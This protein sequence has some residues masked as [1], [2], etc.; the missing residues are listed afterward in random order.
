MP[1]SPKVIAVPPLA[2]PDAARVVL[3]AVLDPAWDEHGS[4][5]RPSCGRRRLGGGLGSGGLGGGASAAVSARL[6]R[7]PAPR[8]RSARRPSPARRHGASRRRASSRPRPRGRPRCHRRW[9]RSSRSARGAGRSRRCWR[10]ERLAPP[11]R[12]GCRRRRPCRSRPSRR[13]GRRWSGPRRSRSRCRRAACA[14]AR[15]PRGRTPTGSSRR[16]RGDRS[17]APGCP[18]RRGLRCADCIALRIA[19]RKLTRLE[20]CSAT[21][22]A[23]SCASISGFLTSRMFSW[24]CLP[25][26]FS[27]S[28]RMRSASAPRRPMTMPGRAVWMSTRTRSRV[29]SIS[30]LEMPA[31]SMPLD[32][33]LRMATSSLT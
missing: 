27:S 13:C 21:P 31:R 12:R 22:W 26:S 9:C 4:A 1:N 5:L 19:R 15:G 16:R 8:R 28:P 25:V 29:R 32:M 23:T 24:T 20:S 33:S 10:G 18:W 3:L 11:A 7:G 14:A 17:T 2:A 6:G 30:T